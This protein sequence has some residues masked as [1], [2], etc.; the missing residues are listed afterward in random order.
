MD[1][2]IINRILS[3]WLR[4]D[5]TQP[6]FIQKR[7]SN[8]EIKELQIMDGT[9]ELRNKNRGLSDGF[10]TDRLRW[11]SKNSLVKVKYRGWVY[12]GYQILLADERY[13]TCTYE[14]IHELLNT[15]NHNEELTVRFKATMMAEFTELCWPRFKE[16]HK[17]GNKDGMSTKEF[18]ATVANKIVPSNV[19]PLPAN[20]KTG[21]VG[22]CYE[23]VCKIHQDLMDVY[24]VWVQDEGIQSLYK[25]AE[26]VPSATGVSYLRSREDLPAPQSAL[27]IVKS[28]HQIRS[29][30]ALG[31]KALQQGSSKGNILMDASASSASLSVN[32][33]SDLDAPE[34]CEHEEDPELREPVHDIVCLDSSFVPADFEM[35]RAHQ[36][37]LEIGGMRQ[38]LH[39]Y[40]LKRFV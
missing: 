26:D 11:A 25:L 20:K 23:K 29:A 12:G 40:Y 37:F 17:E 5:S 28:I 2:K 24:N 16:L 6:S 30:K 21:I 4:S 3:G 19:C 27:S 18:L 34:L 13:I 32:Q 14:F 15:R 7:H 1:S 39:T 8:T 33:F 31:K 35:L 9:V 10:Q 38:A 36:T 22:N